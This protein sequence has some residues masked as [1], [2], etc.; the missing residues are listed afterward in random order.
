MVF[1]VSTHVVWETLFA[2][3]SRK[4][5][6]F[7]LSRIFGSIFQEYPI[8]GKALPLLRSSTPRP[9]KMKILSDKPWVLSTQEYIPHSLLHP[10][11]ENLVRTWH[12]EFWVPKN[13]PPPPWIFGQNLALWI[14]GTQEYLA[15]FPWKWKCDQNLALWVLST[16]EYTTHEVWCNGLNIFKVNLK[17]IPFV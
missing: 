2:M 5:G 16:K 15:P 1:L 6:S 4:F 9:P 17:S 12:F 8:L 3:A 14:L 10:K 11:N 13:T 7:C